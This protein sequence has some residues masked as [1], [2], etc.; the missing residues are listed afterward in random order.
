MSRTFTEQELIRRKKVEENNKLG[1]KSYLKKQKI[2]HTIE[3]INELYST[4][5]KEDL[6]NKNVEVSTY[7][8]ILS[9]RGPF[10]QIRLSESN[11]QIYINNKMDQKLFDF[12]SK[13]DIGD[14]V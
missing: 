13:L 3:Q 4:F 1:I 2:S 6:E 8:R 7:G 11:I 9:K 14:I 10:T 5:S 12:V